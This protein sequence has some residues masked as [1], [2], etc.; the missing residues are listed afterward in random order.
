MARLHA[1][2][3]VQRA[4]EI[5]L[6]EGVDPLRLA[7]V[8]YD[9][10]EAHDEVLEPAQYDD[11]KVLIQPEIVQHVPAGDRYSFRDHQLQYLLLA[12]I[13][14]RQRAIEERLGALESK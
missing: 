9:K 1:G 6:E 7:S 13:A 2:T 8:C 14:W 3:T 5:F 10:W 4:I 11:N 12:S